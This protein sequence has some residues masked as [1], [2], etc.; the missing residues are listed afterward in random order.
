M[1]W[2]G[3]GVL[4]DAYSFLSLWKSILCYMQSCVLFSLHANVHFI[5]YIVTCIDIIISAYSFEVEC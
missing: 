1:L 5:L 4:L 3:T 2:L